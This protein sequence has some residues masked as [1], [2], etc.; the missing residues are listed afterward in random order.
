M[1]KI[2]FGRLRNVITGVAFF[3]LSFTSWAQEI[4]T[5]ETADNAWVLQLSEQKD[6]NTIYLGAKL[7]D[8]SEYAQVV[9]QYQQGTDYSEIYN[10]V[11]TPPGSKNLLE[12]AIQITHADGNTSD[13][14]SVG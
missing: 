5:I 6:L 11:Y 3:C 2:L 12:P 9:K 10:A 1:S 8:Q 14:K 7:K 13:R 4:I